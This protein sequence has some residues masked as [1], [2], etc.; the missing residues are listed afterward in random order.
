MLFRAPRPQAGLT[1]IELVVATSILLV[2]ATM[3]LPV[4][5]MKIKRDKEIE[6]RRALRD[7]R[8]A[9]DRYKDACDRGLIEAK[10]DTECY[11]PD[12]DTLVNGVELAG[13]PDRK[14]RFLRKIPIDPMTGQADWIL[15]CIKDE[16]DARS[17]CGE[18]VFDASS[19]S[20]GTGLDG[21]RYQDW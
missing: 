16:P 2:L 12:L 6:L 19:R 7:I 9:V 21:T 15:R 13:K 10:V 4:T 1:L 8:S 14:V 17:W 5:R 3:A 18:T 20:Y 11:P